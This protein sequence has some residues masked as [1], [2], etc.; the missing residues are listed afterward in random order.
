MKTGYENELGH[1]DGEED[2]IHVA[3]IKWIG[4]SF[5]IN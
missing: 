5:T 1:F 3:A 2:D 4:F